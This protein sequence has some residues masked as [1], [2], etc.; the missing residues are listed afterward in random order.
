[1]VPGPQFIIKMISYQYMILRPSYLHNGI[2]YI[3]IHTGK[4]I[5]IYWIGTQGICSYY[6]C[7]HVYSF[8][9]EY[10]DGRIFLSSNLLLI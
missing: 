7:I 5:Y 8:A 10:V 9:Q 4:T 1:M 6:V 3:D 2:S